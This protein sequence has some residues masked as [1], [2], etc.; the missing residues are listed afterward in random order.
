VPAVDDDPSQQERYEAERKKILEEFG[1]KLA[2]RR[3]TR[4]RLS[5]EAVTRRADVHRTGISALER[6]ERDP[7]LPTLLD[8]ARA[9]RVEPAELLADLPKPKQR[10]PKRERRGAADK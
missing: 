4:P 5:Q 9:Y 3:K 2:L 8:L 7:R 6:G 1:L 10:K